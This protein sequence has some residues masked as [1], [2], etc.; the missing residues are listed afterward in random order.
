MGNFKNAVLKINFQVNNP[1]PT[2]NNCTREAAKE[3]R[4][5]TTKNL[6]YKHIQGVITHSESVGT[7][8]YHTVHNNNIIIIP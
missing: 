8:L 6:N 3:S 4:D 2:G 1:T 5:I 7:Q